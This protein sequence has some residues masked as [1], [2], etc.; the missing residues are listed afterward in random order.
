MLCADYQNTES[1]HANERVR[2][3]SSNQLHSQDSG[4]TVEHQGTVPDVVDGHKVV[5]RRQL[6]VQAVADQP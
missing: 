3:A 1:V 6:S 4:T 5:L 2:G